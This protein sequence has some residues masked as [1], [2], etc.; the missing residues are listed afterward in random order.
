MP[1]GWRGKRLDR[2]VI[3]T[4]AMAHKALIAEMKTPEF[5]RLMADETDRWLK[6]PRGQDAADRERSA[7]QT[8]EFYRFRVSEFTVE[9][10]KSRPKSAGGL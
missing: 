5:K 10:Y 6:T 8:D 7:A 1:S 4:S 3:I 2:A 9:N